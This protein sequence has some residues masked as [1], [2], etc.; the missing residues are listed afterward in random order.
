LQKKIC[1]VM[2]EI[3]FGYNFKRKPMPKLVYSGELFNEFDSNKFFF[4]DKTRMIKTI[5]EQG[6]A[7]YLITRPRRFGKNLN[8]KMIQEFFEKPCKE[9]E[10]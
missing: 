9:E 4:I 6:N 1:D 8:L 2:Y 10:R 5:N 3:N 7:T